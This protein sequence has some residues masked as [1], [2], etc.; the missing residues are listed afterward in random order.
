[1]PREDLG[2]VEVHNETGT[3]HER[4]IIKTDDTGRVTD[5]IRTPLSDNPNK[6]HGHAWNLDKPDEAG[7]RDP[8]KYG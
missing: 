1:M 7:K 4:I 6:D 5:M 3:H 2:N 8:K